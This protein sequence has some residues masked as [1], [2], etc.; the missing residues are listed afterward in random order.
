MSPLTLL[1]QIGGLEEGHRFC[2]ISASPQAYGSSMQETMAMDMANGFEVSAYSLIC[3]RGIII[4]IIIIIITMTLLPV[5]S[6]PPLPVA[7]RPWHAFFLFIHSLPSFSSVQFS[8]VQFSEVKW[9][10]VKW[11]EVKWS[12]VK[13]SEVKW[14]EMKWGEVKWNEMKWSEVK[15]N[16][17]KWSE[18]KWCTL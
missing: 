14:S 16:E 5:D 13:W 9:S 7:P 3:Q 8:S 4:I 2:C 10:S 11:N 17:M 12:E 18:V 6:L 15:W 1:V